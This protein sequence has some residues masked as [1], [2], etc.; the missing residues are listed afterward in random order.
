MFLWADGVDLGHTFFS[1]AKE[2]IRVCTTNMGQYFKC[3]ITRN[4]VDVFG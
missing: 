3:Y 1:H 4:V 2:S